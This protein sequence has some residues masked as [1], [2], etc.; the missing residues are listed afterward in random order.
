MLAANGRTRWAFLAL[1]AV[2]ATTFGPVARAD[3]PADGASPDAASTVFAGFSKRDGGPAA[4]AWLDA[5]GKTLVLSDGSVLV[6]ETAKV[7]RV[8]PDGTIF[9]YA[10]TDIFNFFGDGGLATNAG[11]VPGGMGLALM[12]DGAVLVGDGHLSHR[13]RRVA[14]DGVITTFAGSGAAGPAPCVGACGDGGTALAANLADPYDIEVGP[15]GVVYV[16]TNR[17]RRITTDGN[18][19]AYAGTGSQVYSGDNGLAVNAGINAR[20]MT[21]DVSGNLIIADGDNHRVRKVDVNT[22]IITTIAGTGAAGFSGDGGPATAA[23]LNRPTDVTRASDGSILVADAGNHR[24]RRIALDGTITTVAGNGGTDFDMA[25]DGAAATAALLGLMTAIKAHPTSN[26]V[27][28]SA[29]DVVRRFAVGGNIAHYAGGNVGDGL[30]PPLATFSNEMRVAADI[31]NRVFIADRTFN[32]VRRVAAGAI[33][34]VAGNGKEPAGLCP[35]CGDG[36]SATALALPEPMGIAA[37]PNGDVYISI[38]HQVARVTPGGL[39]HYVAGTGFGC[40]D[41]A[42]PGPALDRQ[43]NSPQG[44]AIDKDGNLFIADTGYSRVRKVAPDG[45]MTVFAG[46]GI[47]GFAGDGGLAVNARLN[48]PTDVAVDKAGNVYIADGGAR[49]RRVAPNGI[50]TTFAGTGVAG[51][52]GDNGQA[53]AAQIAPAAL[54]VDAHGNLLVTDGFLNHIRRIDRVTNVITTVWNVDGAFSVAVGPNGSVYAGERNLRRV[55]KIDGIAFGANQLADFDGNGSSDRSVFRPSTSQWFVRG[56]N[57]ELT[58]YG[59]AGDIPVPGD[60]NGDGKADVAVYRPSTGQWFIR[61]AA[62]VP[63]VIPYGLPCMSDCV[64]GGDQPVPADY[65][66]DGDVDIAIYRPSTGQWFIRGANPETIQYGLTCGS[67]CLTPTEIPVPA[68]YTGDGRV[69]LAVYRTTTGQW[70]VRGGPEGVPYGLSTDRPVPGDYDNDG[71]DDIAVYRPST[72]QW[73]VRGVVPEV[74]QYGV[75]GACCDDVPV[76]ADYDANGATDK[77]IYRRSTGQWFVLGGSP[78][79]VSY[80]AAGDVPLTLPHATRVWVGFLI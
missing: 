40:C 65:D 50:I 51:F 17:V 52:T 79:V 41:D 45:T 76:P 13:I 23:Q 14:P 16:L 47:A 34:T 7:R 29:G 5:P 48:N 26:F 49:V 11:L 35:D 21:L 62:P 25:G 10:G 15:G 58:Q 44:L 22:G 46:N 33:S 77:A 57:P 74:T 80:G 71:D 60:Y 4:S 36:G 68:A 28:V 55:I 54:D 59:V 12:P 31:L 66:G 18:I 70:F 24:V 1:V 61:N 37:H 75:G 39:I 20:G 2:A 43:L 56:G 32:R 78:E 67:P 8:I 42:S 30:A 6:N 53:T 64:Q 63:E 38:A 69:D 19:N 3:S 72:G 9:T 73:F 27:Y